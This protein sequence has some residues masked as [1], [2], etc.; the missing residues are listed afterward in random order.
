MNTFFFLCIAGIFVNALGVVL[1]T[2]L[3]NIIGSIIIVI[4]VFRLNLQQ[5]V[6]KKVKVYSVLAVPFSIAA[7]ALS[8]MPGIED[9]MTLISIC[10]GINIFFFIY[11]TYYFTESMIDYS[12]SCNEMALTRNFRSVWTLCGMIGFIYFMGF[13]ALA[14]IFILVGRILLL[15]A[16]AYYCFSLNSIAKL[17]IIKE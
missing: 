12:K 4:G 17:F 11:F 5:P 10:L 2:F 15:I 16:A 6:F 13:N 14:D 1:N 9:R 7:Y 3:L 8:V